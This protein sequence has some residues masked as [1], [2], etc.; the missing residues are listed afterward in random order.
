M[1][2]I[3]QYFLPISPFA[4]ELVSDY[5][6]IVVKKK[7]DWFRGWHRV[8]MILAVALIYIVTGDRTWQDVVKFFAL[9]FI[10]YCFFDPIL[11]W[12]RKKRGLDYKGQ[13]KN[14]DKWY[15]RFNP[16]FV[17]T[18]RVLVAIGLGIC[19]IVL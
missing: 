9:S 13:T 8:G 11:A 3:L 15:T 12:L 5:V 4:F 6:M 1:K 2:Y 10:P 16:Y 19:Y 14:W 7:K 18:V 17:M